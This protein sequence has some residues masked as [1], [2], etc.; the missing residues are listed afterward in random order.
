MDGGCV[1]SS[2]AWGYAVRGPAYAGIGPQVALEVGS[3]REPGLGR[4][5]S[6]AGKV[7]VRGLTQGRRYA[8]YKVASLGDVPRSKGAA[9]RGARVATWTATAARRTLSVSFQSGRPAYFIAVEA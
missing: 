2:T 9:V 3:V 6:M 1:P 7:T 5:V 4:S 8:L